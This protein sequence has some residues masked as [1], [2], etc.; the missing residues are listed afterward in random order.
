MFGIPGR[1][2]ARGGGALLLGTT[3]LAVGLIW[4]YPGVIAFGSGLVLLAVAGLVSVV[5]P[6]PITFER[7]VSP[8][9]VHRYGDCTATLRVR[10]TGRL[11]RITL[12]A[13][14]FLDGRA[15]PVQATRLGPGETNE[16]SYAIPTTRRGVHVVG[17]LIL[18][19]QGLAG[20]ARRTL[21]L[22]DTVEVRVLPRT[23][24]VHGM[25]AGVRRSHI[26]AV[27]RVEHGGTDLVGLREYMPGDDLRRLHWATS[28]RTGTLMIREDA[29][30][31]RPQLTILLDD[32]ESSYRNVDVDFEDAIEVAASLAMAAI[33]AGHPVNLRTVCGSLTVD[34]PD[35]SN[36]QDAEAMTTLFASLADLAAT[37]ERHEPE[38]LPPHSRDVIAVVSASVADVAPLLLVASE[39][40]VGVALLVDLQCTGQ[41]DAAGNVLVLRGPRAEELL[42]LWDRAV[43]R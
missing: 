15:L 16:L 40:A 8:T 23:L 24:A 21:S 26:G 28:A 14:D 33:Q 20:L 13:F 3:L 41:V 10:H 1:W 12:D 29:D 30:P 36:A 39:A 5:V 19:R 42:S 17:R 4:R 6:A 31:A 38:P 34:V 32:R 2:T 9:E 11:W 22:G 37:S 27:E 35:T 18:H 25:P 43:A 7:K